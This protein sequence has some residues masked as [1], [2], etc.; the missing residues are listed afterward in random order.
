MTLLDDA[1]PALGEL[2]G[3][4]AEALSGRAHVAVAIEGAGDLHLERHGE[5]LVLSL[6][7]PLAPGAD[8]L[9]TYRAALRAV[10]PDALLPRPVQC[11]LAGEAL[12]FLTKH[13]PE[14]SEPTALEATLELLIQLHDAAQS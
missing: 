11:G 2:L 7:R 10:H 4:E 3:L 13:N 12:V 5:Q 6:S 9:T 1:A 8:R 14:D